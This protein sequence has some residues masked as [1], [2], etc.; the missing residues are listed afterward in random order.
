V[1]VATHSGELGRNSG[2]L[3]PW[4][5]AVSLRA[6]VST[7]CATRR[8]SEEEDGGGGGEP[9]RRLRQWR[10][11]GAGNGAVAARS[12]CRVAVGRGEE[13]GGSS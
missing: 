7:G 1:H 8:R 13:N 3:L 4:L 5:G 9:R 6:V 2:E 12:L 10:S 11:S